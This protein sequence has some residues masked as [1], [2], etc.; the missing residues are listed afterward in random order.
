MKKFILACLVVSTII[1]CSP[2]TETASTF[3]AP[4]DLN[5]YNLDSSANIDLVKK[6][7]T[8]FEAGD[9]VTYR[10]C[11]ADTAK[12]HDNGTD[13]TLDQNVG[14]F[15]MFKANGFTLK[16]VSIEP[17]WEIVNKEASAEGI[18]NYVMSFQT[19]IFK[20]GDKEAKMIMS[21]VNGMKDGKIVEEWGLYDT[22][23]ML[24]LMNQ[25]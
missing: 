24:D 22:K 9:S 6:M 18:T 8:A 13:M 20:K 15:G 1:A 19:M 11:Y 2:K 7:I 16:V 3:K 12:F 25:K 21:V 10:S 23:P 4:A 5:S 17:I 14:N